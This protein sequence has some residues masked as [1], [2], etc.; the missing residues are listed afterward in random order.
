MLADSTNG[1][2]AILN[3][4]EEL[5]RRGLA[6]RIAIAA[7]D[8]DAEWLQRTLAD[9]RLRETTGLFDVHWYVTRDELNDGLVEQGCRE[10]RDQI[11]RFDP[12]KPLV[13][14]ELGIVDGKTNDDRQPNVF[15]FGYGVDMADAAIQLM[16]GGSAGFIAWYLDDA[17]HFFGDGEYVRH[18][19]DPLPA[20]AYSRRKVWGMWNS[21]G[22]RMGHPE[23]SQLRPWF[24]TWSL[25]SRYFPAG[26]E[27][28]VGRRWRFAPRRW[29]PRRKSSRARK[30]GISLAI[31]NRTR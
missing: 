24:Y 16:R 25:L 20:D 18:E 9:S 15:G 26:C 21:L 4:R 5:R 23:E 3:L 22:D 1:K 29:Q 2:L 17:M 8:A 7:P 31:V 28:V 6:E 27:I 10:L 14:G 30:V 13:F 19:G 11:A 12:A